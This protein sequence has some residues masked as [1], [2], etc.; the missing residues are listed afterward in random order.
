MAIRDVPDTILDSQDGYKIALEAVQHNYSE[1][2]LQFIPKKI[3]DEYGTTLYERAVRHYSNTIKDVPKEHV[4]KRLVDIALQNNIPYRSYEFPSGENQTNREGYSRLIESIPKE[5]LNKNNVEEI[6]IKA[7]ENLIVAPRELITDDFLNQIIDDD[8]NNVRFVINPSNELL[9][10]AI[11]RDPH[12]LL[13]INKENLSIELCKKAYA[14]DPSIPTSYLPEIIKEEIEKDIEE[15]R[16]ATEGLALHFEKYGLEKIKTQSIRSLNLPSTAILKGDSKGR[17]IDLSI[18]QDRT[19]MF[20]YISD[21]HL[22]HQLSTKDKPFFSINEDDMRKRIHRKLVNMTKDVDSNKT[23][24][25]A[26]DVADSIQVAALFYSELKKV[27]PGRIYTVMGNH[28]LWHIDQFDSIDTA[29]DTYRHE[30][31]RRFVKLLENELVIEYK[32]LVTTRL[33]ELD[34]LNAEEDDLRTVCR[35]STFLLLGGMGFTGLNPIYNADN[36][37]YK[38]TVSFDQDIE[39]SRR[40]RRIYEKLMRC[41]GDQ[42][43]IVL[44]HTRPNDWYPGKLNAGWIHV[45]GHTHK[46]YLVLEEDGTAVFADNQ[47]GY[48]PRPWHLSGFNIDAKKYDSLG[49]LQDGIHHIS[50]DDYLLFNRCQGIHTTYVRYPGEI[51]AIK[52]NGAYLFVL[53]SKSSLCLLAGSARTLLDHDMDYYYENLPTYIESIR[54]AFGPYENALNSISNEIKHIGGIGRIHGCIIDI[55]PLQHIYLNPFDGSIT[56]YFAWDMTKKIAYNNLTSLLIDSPLSV[57]GYENNRILLKNLRE[58]KN[59][60]PILCGSNNCLVKY[61]PPQEVFDRSMYEPS[62]IM[63]S[64][65]YLFSNNI[66]RNWNDSVLDMSVSPALPCV[67]LQQPLEPSDMLVHP[68]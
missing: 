20:Y 15:R 41:A 29:I 25:V 54:A 35:N 31:Q 11:T 43:V 37:L 10:R 5:C 6:C 3:L 46:E 58:M 53:E 68:N 38:G 27:W 32:G 7:P 59:D 2:I 13:E 36:D 39:R 52:R 12:A 40:F 9:D 14:L 64:I 48:S 42:R 26:G 21:I 49:Y 33:T 45:H 28:E 44:T 16:N 61:T 51:Y 24:L 18:E 30:L 17:V 63:M 56:Y 8:P 34:I 4:T 60:L 57:S 1:D 66:V 55:D 22:E 19:D 47:I 65:Q 23:L 67:S 62:R 50:R